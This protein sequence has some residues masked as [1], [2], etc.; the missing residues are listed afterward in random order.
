MKIPQATDYTI[1]GPIIWELVFSEVKIFPKLQDMDVHKDEK[2]HLEKEEDHPM[3]ILILY[4]DSRIW[5]ID[6]M[7]PRLPFYNYTFDDKFTF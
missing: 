6:I 5:Y 2:F 7:S 4:L 3:T 1:L